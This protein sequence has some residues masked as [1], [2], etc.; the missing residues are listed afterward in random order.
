MNGGISE[1]RCQRGIAVREGVCT[2]ALQALERRLNLFINDLKANIE[3]MQ[4]IWQM[5]QR[6]GR[7]RNNVE[8][9]AI[10]RDLNSLETG[11]IFTAE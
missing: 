4:E 6:F 5:T 9:K 10:Q 7:Q 1:S 3:S 2:E 8:N 11:P